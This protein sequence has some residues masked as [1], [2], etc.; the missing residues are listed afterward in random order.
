M[1]SDQRKAG[2]GYLS[3]A[4]YSVNR[5][6]VSIDGC[7]RPGGGWWLTARDAAATAPAQTKLSPRPGGPAK[8]H[9][10]SDS[11]AFPANSS[12]R[13]RAEACGF[14]V[15][16]DYPESSPISELWIRWGSTEWHRYCCFGASCTLAPELPTTSASQ[17]MIAK[18]RFVLSC[19]LD[20]AVSY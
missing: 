18:S 20:V 3:V 15:G 13:E 6:R 7:T 1:P 19:A 4:G 14:P 12:K 8:S 9:C 16:C 11:G 17:N 10:F 2:G 5:R